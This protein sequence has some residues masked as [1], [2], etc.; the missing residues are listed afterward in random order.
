MLQMVKHQARSSLPYTDVTLPARLPDWFP[1]DEPRLQPEMLESNRSKRLKSTVR[2][3]KNH[4]FDLLR[5]AAIPQDADHPSATA[6]KPDKAKKGLKLSTVVA[7]LQQ[8]NSPA[9]EAP[10]ASVPAASVPIQGGQ[11]EAERDSGAV[12]ATPAAVCGLHPVMQ[13]YL[14]H[15]GLTEPTEIQHRVWDLACSGRDVVAQ[16]RPDRV[17]RP[18]T[19][20][21][22]VHSRGECMAFSA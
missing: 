3:E 4:S 7:P 2:F 6:K 8:A 18:R 21:R 14:V 5:P 12:Q 17:P 13:A 19:V 22:A 16:V 10:A 15:Q 11:A 1:A 9:N 20:E